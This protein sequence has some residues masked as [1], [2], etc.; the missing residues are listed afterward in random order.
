MGKS[1]KDAL[2][3]A[4]GKKTLHL[5]GHLANPKPEIP[6]SRSTIQSDTEVVPLTAKVRAYVVPRQPNP[7][8][9][10]RQ[11]IDKSRKAQLER[12]A[13]QQS[14]REMEQ[15]ERTYRSSKAPSAAAQ[16]SKQQEPWTLDI[17]QDAR[18]HSFLSS[19]PQH[20]DVTPP[21]LSGIS[22]QIAR[23]GNSRDARELVI[24]LDF[25]TSSVK[26]IVGDLAAGNAFAVPFSKS[27][28]INRYLLPSRLWQ[29]NERFS[30]LGGM[31]VH[32]DLKLSLLTKGDA[33]EAIQRAAA[34]LALVIRH[35]RGWLFSE[36]AETYA[37][38]K[39][40]WKVVLGI[41]AKNYEVAPEQ[42]YLIKRFLL[43]GRAAWLI[44][45]GRVEEVNIASANGAVERAQ[46]LLNGAAPADESEEVNVEIVPELSAQIYGFLRSNRFDRNAQNIFMMVDVG[47]GTVD[48]SL[49]F[50]E[51]GSRGRWNFTFFTNQVQQSGVM[52]LHRVRVQWWSAAL[53]GRRDPAPNLLRSLY[54]NEFPTDY[55]GTIPERMDE[56]LQ[57]TRLAFR[58]AKE[59]PD[60]EFYMKRVVAQVRGATL[61]RARDYLDQDTLKGIPVFLCG[62]GMR[63]TYYRR[64]GEELKH[65][66]GVSWLKADARPLAIP[67]NLQAPGLVREDY[68]RLSVAFGLSFLEVGSIVREL[69][70]P[71]AT[72]TQKQRDN[73]DRFIS[74]D[75][76]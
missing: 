28:G 52:N 73:D 23:S 37:N 48:S 8:F 66:H 18:A 63:M 59:H 1:I 4:I 29:V 13:A 24:G 35:V 65:F 43:V 45:G 12:K 46:Q 17:D 34:F 38:T 36:H 72:G 15:L 39:I 5:P 70:K 44:A 61:Y 76:V 57:G 68:D 69:P 53:K 50:V 6:K 11:A 40:V 74:K 55:L 60:N 56:Y 20:Y 9:S 42:P 33:Q 3:D 47:A 31:Q 64:L 41:P 51:R 10:A 30:L 75:H 14:Q 49:F 7:R 32:R 19:T 67:N 22:E 26:V 16:S 25:G 2:K 54:E 58:D 62:G 27:D 71:I 21:T